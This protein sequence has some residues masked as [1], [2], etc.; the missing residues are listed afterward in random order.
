MVFY[1]I[2]LGL[3]NH[4][5]I[6]VRGLNAVRKCS[7]VYLE[8]YTSIL[9]YGL[10]K[11]KLEEFYGKEL[12]WADRE[13]VEQK[14]EDMLDEAKTSDVALL[15]VGDPFG[16]TTHADLVLR[17]KQE[18]IP[19][20]CIHNASIMNAVGCC[21]LQL[22]SFGQTVSIVMWETAGS[23]PDSFYDKILINRKNELHTL[24]LLDIKVKEQSVENLMRGRKIYEP[25]RYMSCSDA[26][27][28]LMTI[29]K[30]RNGTNEETAYTKDTMVVGLARVGWDDQKIV[31]CTLEQMCSADLGSPLHCLI[32]PGKVHPMEEEML[33]T[34]SLKQ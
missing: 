13:F 12:F 24:C 19:V 14:A 16:A 33:Q 15:V 8:A 27:K 5:D 31:Y 26:A 34:F 2:G 11:E 18:N 22:Y 4:E 32:I 29:W 3:G 21:G 17:A 28:Q 30:R 25:P 7:K 1:L 9:C 6:T 20:Q 23:E 10:E